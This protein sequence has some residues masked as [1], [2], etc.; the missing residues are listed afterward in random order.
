LEGWSAAIATGVF[1]YNFTFLA[2]SMSI[3]AAYEK[4][5]YGPLL[6]AIHSTKSFLDK[7]TPFV[8][9]TDILFI[10]D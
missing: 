1:N 4:A 9:V 8:R 5:H 2:S 7:N 10:R 6:R 3:L